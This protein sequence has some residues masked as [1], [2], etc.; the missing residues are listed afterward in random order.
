MTDRRQDARSG[1]ETKEGKNSS[2]EQSLNAELGKRT[3]TRSRP[4]PSFACL[5]Q[6]VRPSLRDFRRAVHQLILIQKGK[7]ALIHIEG[8]SPIN[9]YQ[10]KRFH[11]RGLRAGSYLLLN[12]YTTHYVSEVRTFSSS[13]T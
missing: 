4:L 7:L 8:G 12:R 6:D 9:V 3:K 11:P 1:R 10:V 13:G 5:D 2:L